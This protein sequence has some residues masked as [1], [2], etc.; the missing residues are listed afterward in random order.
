LR[1]FFCGLACSA[2]LSWPACAADKVQYAKPAAWVL[3]PPPATPAPTP[4]GAAAR[5]VYSDTQTHVGDKG[6]D[7]YTAWRIRILTADALPVGNITAS[8][9]PASGAATIHHLRIWRDG[10]PIDILKKARFDVIRQEAGLES[11]VLNGILT[12][13]LQT[14][15]LQVG[16]ELE[17]AATISGRDPTLGDHHFGLSALPPL[18]NPGAYRMRLD[19]P[20]A[21]PVRWRASTDMGD[22]APRAQGDRMVIDYSLNDPAPSLPTEGAPLRY[23]LRR[24]LEYSDFASWQDIS[25]RVSTLFDEASR[26]SP[27]SPVQAEIARIAAA[28]ADPRTR[29]EAALALVQDHIR[30]VY[31]G[32]NG[33]NYRPATVE[34]SWTRRFGDCKGKT[35]LLLAILRAL[36]IPAEAVLVQAAGGDGLDQRLPSPILFDHVLVRATIAGK[37][38]WL[39]GTRLGDRHLDLIPPP[40]FRW[41]LPLRKDGAALEPVAPDAPR[42][43]QLIGLEDVDMRAGIDKPAK[44]TLRQIL[45]GDEVYAMRTSLASLSKDD[46]TRQLQSY[47]RQQADWVDPDT[48]EWTYDM[49]KAALILTLTGTGR[50]E[51]KGSDEDGWYSYVHGAGFYTPAMRKRP[52]EQDQSAPFMNEFPRFRCWGTTLRL[53]PSNGKWR[54]TLSGK[55]VNRTL[56]GVAYW[57]GVSIRD[58]VVRTVQSSRSLTPEISAQDARDANDMLPRFDNDMTRVEQSFALKADV[59]RSE[60]LLEPGDAIDWTAPDTPCQG[61]AKPAPAPDKPA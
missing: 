2:I 18:G 42:Q 36:D 16:D 8:W 43:P 22:I 15:G 3:P 47:W 32:L 17:F 27:Q 51:W 25:A 11:A 40:A 49:D 21:R 46:A 9:N 44:V 26:L 7:I 41:V 34:E 12:A 4:A 39:D 53:P 56:G 24:L 37:A 58:N 33:G 57:R 20:A 29:A 59:V 19:W 48:V 10:K 28:S 38:Y 14:P 35:V 31:V 23:N 60:P 45:R 61:P 5:I 50:L 30:Y 13:T 54:W 52:K 55:R 1:L 6:D